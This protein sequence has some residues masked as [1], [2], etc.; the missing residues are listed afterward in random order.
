[1]FKH[2]GNVLVKKKKGFEGLQNYRLEI[3]QF[4]HS[5]AESMWN[6]SE[7]HFTQSPEPCS[8]VEKIQSYS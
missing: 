7:I 4:F 2:I 3:E 6:F 5:I 1:M 8:N